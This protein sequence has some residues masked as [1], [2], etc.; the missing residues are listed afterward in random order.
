MIDGEVCPDCAAER[1]APGAGAGAGLGDGEEA[2]G[3]MDGVQGHAD[4]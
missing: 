2:E 1:I 3:G 4:S